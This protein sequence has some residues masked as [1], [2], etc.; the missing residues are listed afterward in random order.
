MEK[1]R[2]PIF[3]KRFNELRGDMSQD[4]FSKYLGISRPTV[5]FYE[6]GARIP[7]ALVLRQIAEKCNVSVDWLLG[8]SDS[9]QMIEPMSSF[10]VVNRMILKYSAKLNTLAKEAEEKGVFEIMFHDNGVCRFFPECIEDSWRPAVVRCRW[11]LDHLEFFRD[12]DEDGVFDGN[13]I[14]R[15][16]SGGTK[17][18]PGTD[19]PGATKG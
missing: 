10:R 8:L 16:L 17:T 2:F 1:Q 15:I 6:N 12:Q 11:V 14:L 3:A 19:A 18:A 4:E 13:G 5:G 7:D 9:P